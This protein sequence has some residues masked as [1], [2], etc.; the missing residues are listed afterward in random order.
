MGSDMTDA[1]KEM[2]FVG[3]CIPDLSVATETRNIFTKA[4]VI[5]V[6]LESASAGT[7]AKAI[8]TSSSASYTVK[9]NYIYTDGETPLSVIVVYDSTLPEDGLKLY[10]NGMLADSV[11]VAINADLIANDNSVY[12]GNDDNADDDGFGGRIEEIVLY[13]QAIE[14]VSPQS[15]KHVY[16]KPLNAGELSREASSNGSPANYSASSSPL[17]VRR[18]AFALN[19]A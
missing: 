5:V 10:V 17:A 14:V 13:N 19:N 8:V 6:S 3:H 12:V 2:T 4:G 16:K 15:L 1:T 9:S 18:T 11:D 7:Y